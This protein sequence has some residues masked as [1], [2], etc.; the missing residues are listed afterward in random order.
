MNVATRN[1]YDAGEPVWRNGIGQACPVIIPIEPCTH[2]ESTS[3]VV[4]P[5]AGLPDLPYPIKTH[6]ASAKSLAGKAPIHDQAKIK[7]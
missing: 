2:G 3:P 1:V 7:A 5:H 6:S 4:H